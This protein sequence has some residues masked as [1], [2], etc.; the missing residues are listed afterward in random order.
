MLNA[1]LIPEEKIPS[2]VTERDAAARALAALVA[3]PR[4]KETCYDFASGRGPAQQEG[5]FTSVIKA[6]FSM[7]NGRPGVMTPG[8]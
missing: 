7:R 3:D 2:W 6:A 8:T 1:A 5:I 4:Q